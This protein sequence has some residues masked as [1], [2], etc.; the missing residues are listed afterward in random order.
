MGSNNLKI[1]NSHVTVITL[2]SLC[3][4]RWGDIYHVQ[5]EI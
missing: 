3:E 2:S 1:L 4:L 5:G